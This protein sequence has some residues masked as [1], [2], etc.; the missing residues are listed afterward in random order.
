VDNR[1]CC[2]RE[3]H[4]FDGTTYDTSTAIAYQVPL[5][6]G[7]MHTIEIPGLRNDDGLGNF[8]VQTDTASTITF[9]LYGTIEGERR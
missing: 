4:D 6:V 1:H 9:T 7:E 5:A 2:Y 8:A 3:H